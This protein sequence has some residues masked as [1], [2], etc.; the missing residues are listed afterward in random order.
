MVATHRGADNK[1]SSR[2][3]AVIQITAQVIA[4]MHTMP[5]NGL[6]AARPLCGGI[7]LGSPTT[8]KQAHKTVKNNLGDP[9]RPNSAP[10]A[11]NGARTRFVAY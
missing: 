9:V 2:G 5:R 6:V 7:F 4:V 1:E 11:W 3:V 10:W 8:D